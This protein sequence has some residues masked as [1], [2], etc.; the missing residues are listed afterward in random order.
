MRRFRK[1]YCYRNRYCYFRSLL[2][3]HQIETLAQ[4]VENS[5]HQWIPRSLSEIV[6]WHSVYPQ[7]LPVKHPGKF[8]QYELCKALLAWNCSVFVYSLLVVS[9]VLTHTVFMGPCART[10]SP[11]WLLVGKHTRG[12]KRARVCLSA[13]LI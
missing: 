7:R 3:R 2:Q 8:I 11:S 5:E 10:G 9:P 13:D 1:C 6:L 12:H 4:S